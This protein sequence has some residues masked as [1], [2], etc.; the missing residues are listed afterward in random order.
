MAGRW[1]FKT[2]PSAYAFDTLVREKRTT[3]DGVKNAAARKHLRAVARGDLVY[4]YHTGDEK[5]V[6]GV[7]KATS[8]AYADPGSSDPKAVV[9]DIA[10]VHA[11]ARPVTLHELKA[12][13]DL[14]T[15][16]LVRLPRLSVMPVSAREWAT[17]E[18]LGKA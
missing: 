11:L 12:R 6:I 8:D 2:E 17:I 10:A 9:V 18:R 1:L 4:V 5:A 16:P 7:A 3:W 13:P 15:F 14:A